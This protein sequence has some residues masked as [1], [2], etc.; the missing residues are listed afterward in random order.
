MLFARI[1][2]CRAAVPSHR[3]SGTLNSAAIGR[4]LSSTPRGRAS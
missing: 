3:G 1:E 2:L 4:N